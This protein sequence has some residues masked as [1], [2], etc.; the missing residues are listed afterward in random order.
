[1][2]LYAE[3]YSVT[4][5]L[6]SRSDRATFLNFVAQ[7]SRGDWDGAVRTFYRFNNVEE[8][9]YAWVQ[10]ARQKRQA[11]PPS[12]AVASNNRETPQSDPSSRVVVRQTVPPVQPL[13]EAP[14]PIVRGAAPDPQQGTLTGCPNGQCQGRPGFL[15]GY[16]TQPANG[17]PVMVSSPPPGAVILGA[18][19]FD[20][21]GA[22]LGAPVILPMSPQ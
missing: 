2:V 19:Q 18:P 7:G 11:A 8:L 17:Q 14:Q 3:G 4:D 1:M 9:E 13:L 16:A 22:T 15:P 21:P 20:S 5:F 10:H 12:T 6:V